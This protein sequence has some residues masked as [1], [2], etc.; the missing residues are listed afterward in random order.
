MTWPKGDNPMVVRVEVAR[1]LKHQRDELQSRIDRSVEL[2]MCALT[3]DAVVGAFQDQHELI[4]AALEGREEEPQVK[5][6]AFGDMRIL[7]G[8]VGAIVHQRN[9]LLAALNR[10]LP[11]IL[12]KE[13]YV[14]A[15]AAIAS[16]KGG[17]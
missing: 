2:T 8:E 14:E 1:E 17:K 6:R 3:D 7:K 15:R 13:V 12:D 16:V 5:H 10:C 9:E 4:L 11:L